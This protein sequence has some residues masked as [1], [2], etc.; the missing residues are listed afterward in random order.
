MITHAR[1]Q[2]A[3]FLGYDIWTRQD[4]NWHTDGGRSINGRIALGVPPQ[5][6]NF[7]CRTYQ[8]GQGKPLIRS[9][10]SEVPWRACRGAA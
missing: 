5:A 10:Y 2:K 4:D 7:R 3:R 8:R 1:T 9:K 6:V